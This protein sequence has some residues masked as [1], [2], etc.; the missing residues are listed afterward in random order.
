MQTLPITEVEMRDKGELTIPKKIREG[1][2]LETGQKMEL[3]PINDQ[4]ILM[5]PKK[6]ELDEARAQISKI[7]KQSKVSAEEV[8]AGLD[9]ARTETFKKYYGRFS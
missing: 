3:I 8:L 2:H 9:E 4:I 1:L 6:L 5:T 7:L